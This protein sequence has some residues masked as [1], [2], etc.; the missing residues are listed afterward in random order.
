MLVHHAKTNSPFK[1]VIFGLSA[2]SS[3][4]RYSI[5]GLAD[6]SR[7]CRLRTRCQS[8]KLKHDKRQRS[9]VAGGCTR[10]R[11]EP[12]LAPPLASSVDVR[13][14]RTRTCVRLSRGFQ[15]ER[16][17]A[18]RDRQICHPAVPARLA[19]RRYVHCHCLQER[20]QSSVELR[21]AAR[22]VGGFAMRAPAPTAAATG[23]GQVRGFSRSSLPG[24]TQEILSSCE[25]ERIAASSSRSS[26]LYERGKSEP[27][28]QAS[29]SP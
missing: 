25:P 20:Y 8:R 29:S 7:E 5:G 10:K 28:A 24:R 12:Q 27:L 16:Q 3:S 4:S 14:L 6:T 17:L 11:S 26:D 21:S 22:H 18:R 23:R 19:H 15:S 1:V 13:A 9:N 2:R